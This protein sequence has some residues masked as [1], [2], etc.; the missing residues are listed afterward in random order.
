VAALE[1]RPRFL[2]IVNCGFPEAI[3]NETALAICRQ[4][5]V[6]ARLDWMGGLAIGGGGM[7]EG[8][9][10][11]AQGGRARHVVRALALTADAIARGL[12]IPAEARRSARTLPIP[13][14]LYRYVAG[15]GFRQE[16]K[17]RGTLSR[18]DDEPYR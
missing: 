9:P 15:R 1:R 13:A 3:H 12:A 18:M 7:L 6:E 5:A 2:A 11:A 10:L 16:G 8:K 17:R 4:F 14:W